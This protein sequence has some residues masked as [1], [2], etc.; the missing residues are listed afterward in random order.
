MRNFVSI[1]EN[2]ATVYENSI[3]RGLTCVWVAVREGEEVRLVAHW[4]KPEADA[5]RSNEKERIRTIG[6]R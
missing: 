2:S 6:R 1:C 3:R 4:V 5:G